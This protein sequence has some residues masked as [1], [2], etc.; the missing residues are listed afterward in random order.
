MAKESFFR[1]T[2]SYRSSDIL[3]DKAYRPNDKKVEKLMIPIVYK[4]IIRYIIIVLIMLG[5]YD[6]SMKA[7][8]LELANKLTIQFAGVVASTY[9]IL[10]LVLKFI[11]QSKV[12]E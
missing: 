7:Y 10:T 2:Y 11:F 6:M 9:A 12:G 8:E 3:L 5:T 1:Y 4:E